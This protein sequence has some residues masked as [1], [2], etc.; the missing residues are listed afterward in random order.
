MSDASK[1][2]GFI[3]YISAITLSAIL[4]VL[5]STLSF[6]LWYAQSDFLEYEYAQYS[7]LAAAECVDNVRVLL[8]QNPPF[9]GGT[10]ILTTQGVCEVGAVQQTASLY[11]FSVAATYAAVRTEVYIEADVASLAIRSW[12]PVP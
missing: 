9:L 3:A 7:A 5:A 2:R 6:S 11:A 1:S 10:S 12:R 8:L 4:L